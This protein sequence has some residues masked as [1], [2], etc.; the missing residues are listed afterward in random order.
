MN[1]RLTVLLGSDFDSGF[2]RGMVRNGKSVLWHREDAVFQGFR[3]GYSGVDWVLQGA[4]ADSWH[5]M[6]Q[7]AGCRETDRCVLLRMPGSAGID[8]IS[9]FRSGVIPWPVSLRQLLEVLKRP[10]GETDQQFDAYCRGTFLEWSTVQK[11]KAV[12][13][14][15]RGCTEP[16]AYAALRR[17]SMERCITMVD[18]ARSVMIGKVRA[19]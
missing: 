4:D 9:G 2:I 14:Q 15:S 6:L 7:Q 17:M 18:A 5:Q 12:I 11:A 13:I 3:R 10:L 16:E 8:V 19:L 1:K